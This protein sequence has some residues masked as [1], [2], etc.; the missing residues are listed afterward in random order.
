MIILI[1]WLKLIRVEDFFHALLKS[2]NKKILAIIRMLRN[3]PKQ[4]EQQQQ[5]QQQH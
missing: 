2:N 4:L 1:N 3:V 5:Q